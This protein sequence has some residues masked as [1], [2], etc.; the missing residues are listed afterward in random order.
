M[1]MGKRQRYRHGVY[2]GAESGSQQEAG[3][4][5]DTSGK[6]GEMWHNRLTTTGTEGLAR[7]PVLADEDWAF[8]WLL[9]STS[10]TP[11]L[12]LCLFPSAIHFT[13]KMEATWFSKTVVSYCNTKQCHNLEDDLNYQCHENLKSHIN[14]LNAD[15]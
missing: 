5:S 9:V 12:Y 2:E 13:L 1:A 6:R 3:K 15:C 8:Y 11:S 4:D 7:S 10:Y 14:I